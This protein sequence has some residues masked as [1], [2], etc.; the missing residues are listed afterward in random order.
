MKK[1]HVL[2]NDAQARRPQGV[3]HKW[4]ALISSRA[5]IGGSGCP[6]CNIKGNPKKCCVHNNLLVLYPKLCQDWDYENNNGK[7]PENYLPGSN[8]E[9][10][11][12]CSKKGVCSCHKWKATIKNRTLNKTGCPFCNKN[13]P[14]PHNNL[15]VLRP[16]IVKEWD[17]D[18]NEKGPEEYSI[19]SNEEAFWKCSK[20]NVCKCHKWKASID[21]RVI[22]NSGCPFCNNHKVCIHNNLLILFPDLC[23]EWNY[24]ENEKGPEHYSYGSSKIASWKCLKKQCGFIWNS[25]ISYRTN[26]LHNSNCPKCSRKN[27]SQLCINWLT[28]IENHLNIKIQHAEN[29][30][31]KTIYCKNK[32]Y[33][34]DGYCEEFNIGFE[35]NG[36][37]WHGCKKCHDENELNL[38]NKE[39]MS[40]LYNKTQEKERNLCYSSVNLVFSIWECQYYKIIKDQNLLKE[41]MNLILSTYTKFDLN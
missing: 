16:D 37:Y 34:L 33:K 27:Y 21:N 11:W 41:I 10:A 12:K 2:K 29:D 22:H 40:D 9:I 30:G 14:C 35:V 26:K 28:L 17:Y 3:C 20:L 31:E 36:C 18:K 32:R 1:C 7:R 38:V 13:K 24:D 8:A 6:F 15:L 39:K 25:I 19:K 5:R 23:K 4:P